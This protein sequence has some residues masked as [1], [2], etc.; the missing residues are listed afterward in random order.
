MLLSKTELELFP[1]KFIENFCLLEIPVG[2]NKAMILS[3]IIDLLYA[4][5][6]DLLKVN[7]TFPSLFLMYA[8]GPKH[9][10]V[11]LHE[12]CGGRMKVIFGYCLN[13]A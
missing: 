12:L 3:M 5:A 9:L 8:W 6:N 10:G 7:E 4:S 1:R 11:V 13:G 2:L